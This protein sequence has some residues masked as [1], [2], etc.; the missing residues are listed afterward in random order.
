M[1]WRAKCA[2]VIP[3]L[4]E[5]LAIGPL[6]Q[7]VRRFVDTVY[8]VDD[9]STDGT[10]QSA[11]GVGGELLRHETTRGKGAALRTGWNHAKRDGFTWVLT[12]DGDGQHSADDI[13]AF[14]ECIEQTSATL[15]IGNRM[16]DAQSMPCLRRF[17]NR[18]MSRRL[19]RLASL[20]LPDSQCGFR[21]IDLNALANISIGT[22]HFEIE[23]ELLLGFIQRGYRVEFIPI[24]VIYKSEQ[25]KIQPLRDTYRWFHWWGKAKRT[26]LPKH[27]A[28]S[29]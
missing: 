23:S 20:E 1:D 3:C 17:V 21:L 24:Q 5:K 27:A 22:A 15:V 18:W 10:G 9:G 19:S 11:L 4:N 28:R 6:V 14:F 25:S 12:M 16:S 13:P 8:I 7:H 29:L 26:Q 2:A